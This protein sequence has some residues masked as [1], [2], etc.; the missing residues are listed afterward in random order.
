M[1][2]FG[3]FAALFMGLSLGAIGGGGSILIIPI[4]VYLFQIDP[5]KATVYSLI[6]VGFTAFVGGVS[7]SKNG[8]VAPRK[9]IIFAAPS[10][11]SVFLTRAYLVPQ[12]PDP[13]IQYENT[14]I[15][16]SVFTMI[17]FSMLMLL[18]SGSMIRAGNRKHVDEQ[19]MSLIQIAKLIFVGV[20]VGFLSGLLGA[21]GGFLIIPSLIFLGQLPMKKAIGTSLFII[22]VN[23]I[24]GFMGQMRNPIVLDWKLILSLISISLIG[25]VVGARVSK[26]VSDQN[27]KKSFGYFVLIIGFAILSDQIYHLK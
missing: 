3:Y 24:I 26:K 2:I 22:A 18:A 21:G 8:W 17:L 11:I 25:M 5:M 1:E 10:V 19:A 13:I 4:L 14:Q 27:L 20:L 16:Q 7:Y 6:V 9:G 15:S 23:S 12:L